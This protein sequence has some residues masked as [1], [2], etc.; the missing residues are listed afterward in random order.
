MYSKSDANILGPFYLI[1]CVKRVS[2]LDSTKCEEI[3]VNA[4][5]KIC[6]INI[7]IPSCSN[8]KFE[9]RSD[10]ILKTYCIFDIINLG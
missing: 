3:S 10:K 7:T 1:H 9:Y 2:S 6:L 4:M 8:L 5:M